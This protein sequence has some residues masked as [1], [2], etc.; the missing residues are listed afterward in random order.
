MFSACCDKESLVRTAHH[1]STEIP[2]HI[3]SDVVGLAL[4]LEENRETDEPSNADQSMAVDTAI[5]ELL[6]NLNFGAA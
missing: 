6:C 5:A 1:C 3:W 2:Y 4:A